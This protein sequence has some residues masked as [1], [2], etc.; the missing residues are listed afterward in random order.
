MQNQIELAEKEISPL[1]SDASA[2]VIKTPDDM[3]MATSLL[4]QMNQVMD[5][6]TAEKEKVTRPL[7]DALNAERNRWNPIETSFKQ[8][9]EPLRDKIS[10]YQTEQARKQKEEADRLAR[11]VSEGSVSIDT[12]AQSLANV[13]RA[14]DRV[15]TPSGS[16]VFREKQQLKI[17]NP[18]KVPKPYWVIDE[19]A[20]FFALTAGESVPGAEIEIIQVPINRR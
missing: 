14:A 12:A 2:L 9:I 13:T 18:K 19:E 6:V 10:K 8:A 7:L 1:V 5:S 20:V 16:L 4:S 3:I 11:Q 17:T 15:D